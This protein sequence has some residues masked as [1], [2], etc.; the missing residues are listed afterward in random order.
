LQAG[1]VWLRNWAR[2]RPVLTGVAVAFLAYTAPAL[3][4]AAFALAGSLGQLGALSGLLPPGV[5]QPP[6]FGWA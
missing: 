6:G 5:P 3:A 2:R 4:S 1:A